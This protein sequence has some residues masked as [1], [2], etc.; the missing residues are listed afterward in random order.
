MAHISQ[1]HRKG[2][3]HWETQRG[4]VRLLIAERKAH[5]DG[6]EDPNPVGFLHIPSS[7]GAVHVR[8]N[9]FMMNSPQL[10]VVDT[11]HR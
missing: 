4:E 11:A 10:D 7:F 5:V 1:C 8:W 6:G 9:I 3:V 2:G